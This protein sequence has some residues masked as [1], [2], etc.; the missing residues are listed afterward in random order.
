MPADRPWHE[1]TRDIPLR[2]GTYRGRYLAGLLF[3]VSGSLALQGANPHILYL[4]L[5]GTVFH[6]VGWAIMPSQG[7]RRL[8]VVAPNI[9]VTW[10]LLTGPQSVWMLAVPYLS[11]LLVRQ[12]PL[13][14]YITLLFVLCASIITVQ[15]L[16]EYAA[17][18]LA[19]AVSG[20]ALTASAWVARLLA[21]TAGSPSKLEDIVG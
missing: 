3:I 21:T 16:H 10:L 7:W 15:L 18:P 19:L 1:P 12:R 5:A 2:W 20:V 14:S 11:W 13:R 17:M 6:T 4:L 8:V 9:A